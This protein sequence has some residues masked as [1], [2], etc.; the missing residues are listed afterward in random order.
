MESQT[1]VGT[2][3]GPQLG[4]AAGLFST[5]TG[6]LPFASGSEASQVPD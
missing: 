1:E 4:W 3:V 2:L 6:S 5:D